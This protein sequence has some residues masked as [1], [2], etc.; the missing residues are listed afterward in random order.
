MITVSDNKVSGRFSPAAR[1][2]CWCQRLAK[3]SSRSRERWNRLRNCCAQS[4]RASWV[5]FNPKLGPH[6]YQEPTPNPS[7]EGSRTS[8]PNQQFPSWEGPGVGR[9]MES[10]QG[11]TTAHWDHEPDRLPLKDSGRTK[12]DSA[13]LSVLNLWGGSSS[14]RRCRRPVTSSCS[15]LNRPRQPSTFLLARSW[16]RCLWFAGS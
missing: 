14:L 11:F 15:S 13:S 12:M 1:D 2:L 10:L 7:E 6:W 3:E 9:L 4:G 16:F 8:C 5:V